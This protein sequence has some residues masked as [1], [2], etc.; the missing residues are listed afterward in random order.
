[1]ARATDVV[2]LNG[3]PAGGTT[4]VGRRLAGAAGHRVGV[5]GDD[6]KRFVVATEPG[7]VAQGLS[8]RGGA[9]LADVFLDAGY[10]MVVFEFVFGRRLNV[11]RFVRALRSHAAVHLLTLWAPLQT[12]AARDAA[13]PAGERM[14]ARVAESWHELAAH[15][16]NQ[17]AVIDASGPVDAVVTEARRRIEERASV[18]ISPRG[19]TFFGEW[20]PPP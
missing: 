17:G 8:Y 18:V 3:P 13:R 9:A 4:T 15:L 5:H 6:R 1:M 19:A 14:G 2:V 16:D 11:G 20:R 12:V 7:T 10:D